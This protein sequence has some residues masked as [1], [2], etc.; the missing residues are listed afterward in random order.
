MTG[1]SQTALPEEVARGVVRGDERA[2]ASAYQCLAQPVLNLAARILRDRQLAE[3]VLQDTFIELVEKSTQIRDPDAIAGW[4]RRVAT[5][6]CLMKL[7]S[8]WMAKRVAGPVD[9]SVEDWAIHAGQDERV[10][11]P[12]MSAG[13]TIEEAVET[14]VRL[15]TDRQKAAAQQSYLPEQS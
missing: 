4:V 14:A 15:V 12:D 8:P 11:T 1:I 7:R 5:N 13:E 2:L 9:T 3:E 10:S 6:H